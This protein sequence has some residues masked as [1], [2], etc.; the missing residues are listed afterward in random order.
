MN[1][2]CGLQLMDDSDRD[3]LQSLL[4][5]MVD[6]KSLPS[7][8]EDLLLLLPLRLFL[9]ALAA[10]SLSG[11]TADADVH[12][13]QNLVPSQ[14]PPKNVRL[15]FLFLRTSFTVITSDSITAYF[16]AALMQE[17]LTSARQALRSG[18]S[19]SA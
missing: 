13:R 14:C 4:I 11:E 8:S 7:F 12:R 10:V 15:L 2:A 5:Q 6:V 19:S 1:N 9:R 17:W 18:I 16:A 3:V